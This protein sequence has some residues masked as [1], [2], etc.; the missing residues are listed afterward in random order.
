MI[1]RWQWRAHGDAMLLAV[2]GASAW[3]EAFPR[4]SGDGR[5]LTTFEIVGFP[6]ALTD[7]LIPL[8]LVWIGARVLG[9]WRA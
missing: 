5:G 3:I 8:A 4:L 1:L 6:F 2:L 9:E 7:L